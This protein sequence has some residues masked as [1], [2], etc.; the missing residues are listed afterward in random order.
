MEGSEG[1]LDLGQ[2]AS[3]GETDASEEDG[4]GQAMLSR[5]LPLTVPL[6]YERDI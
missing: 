3:D 5:L 2:R 4:V 1:P 6:L